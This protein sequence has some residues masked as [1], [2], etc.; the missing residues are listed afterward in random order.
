[1]YGL[2]GSY[3]GVV[4][5]ILGFDAATSG[6][7]L[8]GFREWLIVRAGDGN[9]LAWT[10]LV[11]RI[12]EAETSEGSATGVQS[13]HLLQVLDEFLEERESRDGIVRIYDRYLIWL[14]G[15]D[16]FRPGMLEKPRSNRKSG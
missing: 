14:R 12:V 15:Q 9:N 13:D 2:D 8:L 7:A 10:A 4:A 1:M 6:A 3:E 11:S 5:F 16:W